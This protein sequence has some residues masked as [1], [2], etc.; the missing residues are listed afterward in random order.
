MS[1]LTLYTREDVLA[2]LKKEKKEHTQKWNR[3]F[4]SMDESFDKI[5]KANANISVKID[6]QIRREHHIQW[7]MNT[8]LGFAAALILFVLF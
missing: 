2:F 7:A 3:V 8:I 6:R 4:E 1:E 5:E